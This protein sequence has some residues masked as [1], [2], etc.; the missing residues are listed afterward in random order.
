MESKVSDA[1]T[2]PAWRNIGRAWGMF[3]L[4]CLFGVGCYFLCRRSL[5]DWN[6]LMVPT[7]GQSP[8]SPVLVFTLYA[9]LAIVGLAKGEVI[10][11]RKVMAR[12]LARARSAIGETGWPGDAFLAPFCMLSLYRPW[13]ISHAL[14]SWLLIPLMVGLAFFF[15]FGLA[16]FVDPTTESLVRGSVYFGIGLALAY[17]ALVYLAALVRFIGWWLSGAARE[18]MPLPEST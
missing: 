14:S 3:V 16:G 1:T 6:A 18:S 9:V 11:R 7:Q 12:S 17:G 2:E 13:K 8:P 15:R 5:E 4:A 10:F